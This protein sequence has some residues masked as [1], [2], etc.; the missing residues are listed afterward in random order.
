[1]SS[2]KILRAQVAALP[3]FM[4]GARWSW[5]WFTDLSAGQL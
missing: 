3:A 4:P 2:D 1:M 5:P